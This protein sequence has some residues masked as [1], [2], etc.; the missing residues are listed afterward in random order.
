M[1]SHGWFLT[2][3]LGGLLAAIGTSLAAFGNVKY[4]QARESEKGIAA[5]AQAREILRAEARENLGLLKTFTTTIKHKNIPNRKL[6]IAG[7][8]AVSKSALVLSMEPTEIKTYLEAYRE[9]AQ[10]NEYHGQIMDLTVG[11]SSALMSAATNRAALNTLWL[12]VSEDLEARLAR[13]ADEQTP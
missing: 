11:V 10:W 9:I 1:T 3:M 4:A 13:I 5:R 7:W 2:I 8:E 6:S 12:G